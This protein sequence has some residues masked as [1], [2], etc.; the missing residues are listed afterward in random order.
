MPSGG[1]RDNYQRPQRVTGGT[2]MT[3]DLPGPQG[4]GRAG[5]VKDTGV[6]PGCL[7]SVR[8]GVST[9]GPGTPG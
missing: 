7:R 1:G 9:P 5:A 8:G 3:R 6:I 4:S 2:G